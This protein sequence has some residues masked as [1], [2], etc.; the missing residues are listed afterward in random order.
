MKLPTKANQDTYTS[1]QK[2]VEASLE[3]SVLQRR[4]MAMSHG[5]TQN[6]K[7]IDKISKKL[8]EI[9]DSTKDRDVL[10]KLCENM[11]IR[12]FNKTPSHITLCAYLSEKCCFIVADIKDET[13][14]VTLR[15][16]FELD[17]RVENCWDYK[18]D[19]RSGF[20]IEV[21]NKEVN[22]VLTNT[23]LAKE[24]LNEIFTPR[25][26]VQHSGFLRNT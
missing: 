1:T 9:S 4:L 16:S 24:K 7:T 14:E 17:N 20:V 21:I 12:S 18:L 5:Q 11:L 19:N 6:C 13:V 26:R 23:L 2:T 8:T 3:A 10:N 22:P 15:D 25:H